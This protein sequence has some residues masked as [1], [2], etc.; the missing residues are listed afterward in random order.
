MYHDHVIKNY[1][2]F[3]SVLTDNFTSGLFTFLLFVFPDLPFPNSLMKPPKF[4]A[5]KAFCSTTSFCLLLLLVF[6]MT[7]SQYLN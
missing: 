1:F 3:F 6:Y 5:W 7:F 4:Y 2:N